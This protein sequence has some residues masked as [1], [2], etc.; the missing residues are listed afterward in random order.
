MAKDGYYFLVPLVTLG[1]VCLF[2]NLSV[3]AVMLGVLAAFVVFFF[4]DPDRAVPENPSAIVSPADGRI[5]GLRANNENLV[6]SIF[7]SIF[8]VHVNRAPISGLITKQEYRP[9][10]FKIA[11]DDEASAVNEQ[12]A[13][14]ITG[15]KELTF[16]LIA[17]VLARRIC[18]WKKPGDRVNKG[19]RIALIR[20][21]SRV[22][23]VLPPGVKVA[24]VK[25]DRVYAG[26]TI[27]A[28]WGSESEFADG[29]TN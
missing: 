25:G 3:P 6:L 10:R 15:E 4:R 14:T 19:D 16:S 27:I 13:I 17:G 29:G 18:P 1:L 12:M 5:I 23:V 22:D 26:S 8:N 28:Y 11:Y 20:F 2:I 21:G 24:V 7:L 9:G